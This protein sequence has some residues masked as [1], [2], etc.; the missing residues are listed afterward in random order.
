MFLVSTDCQRVSPALKGKCNVVP[1]IYLDFYEAADKVF[2]FAS[3]RWGAH[4]YFFSIGLNCRR[5]WAGHKP[6]LCHFSQHLWHQLSGLFLYSPLPVNCG[7]SQLFPSIFDVQSSLLC[8]LWVGVTVCGLMVTLLVYN[9]SLV[10]NIYYIIIKIDIF[11][12]FFHTLLVN[13]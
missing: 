1:V 6:F 5:V 4:I 11:L 2:L 10:L 9:M 3:G 8:R 7:C 13:V 12:I